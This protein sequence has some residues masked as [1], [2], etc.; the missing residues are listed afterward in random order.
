V[1][2][3]IDRAAPRLPQSKAPDR[4]PRAL[5][6]TEVALTWFAQARACAR[7]ES[8]GE[9]SFLDPSGGA[10][11]SVY[12]D[13]DNVEVAAPHCTGNICCC[14]R[15]S[16]PTA[17]GGSPAPAPARRSLVERAGIHT[18]AQCTVRCSQV[19]ILEKRAI[20]HNLRDDTR[21]AASLYQSENAPLAASLV[22][23][24][25]VF[26]VRSRAQWGGAG[27]LVRRIAGPSALARSTHRAASERPTTEVAARSLSLG[28]Q[29]S[30]LVQRPLSLAMYIGNCQ[31]DSRWPTASCPVG[32]LHL[33][34]ALC[35]WPLPRHGEGPCD[36]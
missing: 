27:R 35:I 5:F 20:T 18:G 19:Y 17:A 16:A 34:L 1:R 15:L 2:R 33:Q 3:S 22:A 36:S 13:D 30:W 24:S 26:H 7:S 8:L 12:A 32:P 31:P 6:A 9:I 4:P 21:L 11:A 29:E 28:A 23:I 25:S 14:Y 10:S